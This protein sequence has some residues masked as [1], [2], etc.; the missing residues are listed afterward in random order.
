M[1]I[2]AELVRN[3]LANQAD[4]SAKST[5]HYYNLYAVSVYADMKNTSMEVLEWQDELSCI[6]K[7]MQFVHVL[8]FRLEEF[9][10]EKIMQITSNRKTERMVLI[11]ENT[12][13]NV[14]IRVGD[15]ITI[16]FPYTEP[17]QTVTLH[18]KLPEVSVDQW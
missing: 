3:F 16:L 5:Y 18:A 15:T 1:S 12:T 8:R 10:I 13:G 14:V 17:M 7:V 2:A 4:E 6:A 9:I 11:M